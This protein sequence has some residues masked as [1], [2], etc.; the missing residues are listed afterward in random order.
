MKLNNS[1]NYKI[2]NTYGILKL[3]N[4]YYKKEKIKNKE[5]D[6]LYAETQCT[7]CGKIKH[8]RARSLY[9]NRNN[10]CI[11]QTKT[12][13]GLNRTKIYSIWG[14]MKNRCYNPRC[15]A[16]NNYGGR[17]IKI[18]DD[19]KNNFVS[20]YNWAINNG[21]TD[22]LSIDRINNNGDYEPNNCQ[23]LTVGQNVAKAN[24]YNIRRKPNNRKQYY[25]VSPN[26]TEYIFSNA[27]KFCREYKEFNLNANT[28]RE[29]SRG[30]HKHFYKEWYCD[31]LDDNSKER[32]KKAIGNIQ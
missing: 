21:Y 3:N 4:L 28:L 7:K 25:I 24:I 13:L 2:G 1:Y 11:C 9:Y 29:T 32:Y 17:G 30:L 18:C 8:M 31:Y 15:H 14:N 19:W 12:S 26:G 5:Y 16:Y 27:N 6:V 10:S 23:W 22:G 20:F